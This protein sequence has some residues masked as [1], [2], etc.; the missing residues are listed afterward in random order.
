MSS[1]FIATFMLVL[2]LLNRSSIGF[3]ASRRA[4]TTLTRGEYNTFHNRFLSSCNFNEELITVN[5]DE[6]QSNVSHKIL[7]TTEEGTLEFEAKDGELLRTAALRRG[8]VTPHN[9][10]SKLINC[11]GLGTCGTCAVEVAMGGKVEPGEKNSRERLR[12]SF[13]PHNPNRQSP[14]LRLACQIQVRGDLHVTK[15][16]GFWGQYDD[17]SP[18]SKHET[19][20]GD[21]E[22]IL[23]GRSPNE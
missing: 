4:A 5:Q 16:S 9:G 7:W 19:Y 12:L 18:S 17:L 3:T 1:F 13:P 6:K 2:L 15:R 20:F 11:R 22:Y 14:L 8:I 10:K 23:D 21:L